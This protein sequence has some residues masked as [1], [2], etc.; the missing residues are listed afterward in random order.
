M[1][2]RLKNTK[3]SD[4]C[5]LD[6]LT[7]NKIGD[8]GATSISEALKTNTTLTELDLGG[9]KQQM[10]SNKHLFFNRTKSTGN[11]IGGLGAKA[12]SESLKVNTKLISLGLRSEQKITIAKYIQRLC[13]RFFQQVTR[14]EI[15]EQNLCVTL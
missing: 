10:V 14:L 3:R 13:S 6:V 4:W 7:G 8:T 12:L 9:E 15:Q 2:S 11:V 5:F 1:R